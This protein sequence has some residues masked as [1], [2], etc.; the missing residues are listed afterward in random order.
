MSDE[1]IK[2]PST[3]NKTLSPSVNYVGT[4]AIVKF[5]GYCLKQEKISFNHRKIVKITLFMKQIDVL[6]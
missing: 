4:K 2:L 3:S 6:I 1:S 5:N